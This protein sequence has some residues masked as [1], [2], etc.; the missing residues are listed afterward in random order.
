[1]PTTPTPILRLA[2]GPDRA[3]PPA[4]LPIGVMVD[5]AEGLASARPLWEP[6]LDIA[7]DRRGHIRLIA[8]DSYE[9]WLITWPSGHGVDLHDHGG[10]AGVIAVAEGEL[11]EV[12]A[13]GDG[14]FRR[15]AVPAGASRVVPPDRVHDV[16]N[17]GP[18][19]AV[20][21]HV[22][23]PPLETMTF[24]DAAG[25]TPVRTERVFPEE[26]AV[27]VR[28]ASRSLHPSARVPFTAPVRGG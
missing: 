3:D 11:V 13:A 1:M 5:I 15:A 18:T 6:A 27:S 26:P 28:E 4:P 25:I 2:P 19:A 8:T 23:A 20:S 9:A 16:L 7:D 12:E 14:S 10:S 21:I 17:I 24:Y 22:Y